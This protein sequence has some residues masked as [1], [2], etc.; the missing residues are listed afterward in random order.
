MTDVMNTGIY[1]IEH[2]E[3]GKKYIGSTV[4]FGPRWSDHRKLLR[5][6]THPSRYLQN[7]WNKYGEAAFV[8]KKLLVCSKENLL[9]YEQLCIDGYE[10]LDETKGY[11]LVPTAGSQLGAKRSPEACARIRAAR[12]TQACPRTGTRH[13]L[14]SRQKMRATKA[15]TSKLDLGKADEIRVRRAAGE[16]YASLARAYGV[17]REAVRDIV[18]GKLWRPIE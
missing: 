5:R 9:M 3:S 2:L 6:N 18:V 4:N 14:E 8:F 16:R 12:A 10:V 1:C 13:S 7:A 15:A 17:S 11:N